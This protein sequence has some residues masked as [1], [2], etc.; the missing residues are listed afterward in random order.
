MNS[1][2]TSSAS[3]DGAKLGGPATITDLLKNVA[4]GH[5]Q[6]FPPEIEGAIEDRFFTVSY[7]YDYGSPP[8]WT[9]GPAF[10]EGPF[11]GHRDK[12]R[13]SVTEFPNAK[14]AVDP[15]VRKL[16]DFYDGKSGYYLISEKL[17]RLIEELDPGS[18]D[19]VRIEFQEFE[20]DQPYWMCMPTRV[21]EAVDTK[22]T[23]V[24]VLFEKYAGRWFRRV[25]FPDCVVFDHARLK[26]VSNFN[27]IDFIDW[28]WSR[29]LV[30]A[31]EGQGIIGQKYSRAGNQLHQRIL[32]QSIF[33]NG[34]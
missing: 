22:R 28:Q 31:A 20:A 14:F 26:D 30:E 2:S 27:D 23:Q 9:N 25:N 7:G 8:I 3:C 4:E 21:I 11:V 32:P 18:V 34:S 12:E 17:R 24:S 1:R 10:G 19:A 5:N 13:I 6:I 16:V 29:K 15:E 33:N